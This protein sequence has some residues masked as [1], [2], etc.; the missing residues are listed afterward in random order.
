MLECDEDV[1]CSYCGEKAEV[2]CGFCVAWHCLECYSRE[3]DDLWG[4][5]N[6]S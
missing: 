6:K 1:R 4:L 3:D 5:D 2:F